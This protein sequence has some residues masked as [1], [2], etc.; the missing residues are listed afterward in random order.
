MLE[1]AAQVK[2]PRPGDEFGQPEFVVR[3]VGHSCSSRMPGIS[4]TLRRLPVSPVS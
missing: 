2:M 3:G 4:V 1:T